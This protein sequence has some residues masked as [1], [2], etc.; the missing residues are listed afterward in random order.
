MASND[1]FKIASRLKELK[2]LEKSN[3]VKILSDLEILSQYILVA[4]T[5]ASI[6]P[7]TPTPTCKGASRGASFSEADPFASFEESPLKVSPTT[8]GL[9]PPPFLLRAISL[10][11]K[12]KGWINDGTFPNVIKLMRDERD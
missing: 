6:P 11:P 8:I 3:L 7:L 4:W 10:T 2:A 5:A 9:I 12:K 1:A